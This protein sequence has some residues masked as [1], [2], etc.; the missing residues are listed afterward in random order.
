MCAALWLGLHIFTPHKIISINHMINYLLFA[1][2][3]FLQL[4]AVVFSGVSVAF[5]V[6]HLSPIDPVEAAIRRSTRNSN[7]NPEAVEKMRETLTALYGVDVPMWQ[8][9]TNFW[10]KVVVGDFGPSLLSFPTPTMDLVLRALPWTVGLL[11]VTVLVTWC[12]GNFL[13]AFAGYFQNNKYLKAFGIVT[14]SI[15]PIPYYIVAFL[16]LI[17][18]AFI[19]PILP[20]GGGYAIGLVQEWS[21]VFVLSVMKHAILPILSLILVGLGL[22]FLGMRALVSNIISEDYVV[23]AELA[24]V[25]KPKIV[26]SYVMR[27]ALVP[28]LTALAMAIGGIFSGT[29]ITEQVFSYPGLGSLLVR[30][31]N[32]GDYTLVLAVSSVA[33][34]AVAVAIFIVDLLHPLL[35]PRIKVE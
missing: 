27:N 19:W 32:S 21:W 9:F 1:A 33:V 4:V 3:R 20:L 30:A 7:V 5:F 16:T 24:G 11:L 28:Q 26:I 14:M 34:A 12:I 18:L 15:Q 17:V 29:I 13:G 31:V 35:D 25:S 23:F 10:S 6:S 22:W 8:Q 2:K